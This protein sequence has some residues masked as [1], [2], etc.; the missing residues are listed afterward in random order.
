MRQI[1]PVFKIKIPFTKRLYEKISWC[2]GQ[3]GIYIYDLRDFYKVK[4]FRIWR[5]F[6]DIIIKAWG[7]EI[8]LTGY[9]DSTDP[10]INCYYDGADC[11]K[12]ITRN[13][14]YDKENL[15]PCY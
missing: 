3:Y 4:S 8:M 14:K 12:D 5:S 13:Y 2:A 15:K 10:C 1:Q 9:S 7:F 11:I 6:S